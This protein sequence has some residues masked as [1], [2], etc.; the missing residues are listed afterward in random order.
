MFISR[1]MLISA[2]LEGASS[3]LYSALFINWNIFIEIKLHQN[4]VV[5]CQSA[6]FL[7]FSTLL[8]FIETKMPCYL[9]FKG[10]NFSETRHVNLMLFT[11]ICYYLV[12]TYVKCRVSECCNI[13]PTGKWSFLY[14]HSWCLNTIHFRIRIKMS[15][16]ALSGLS[17]GNP[18]F[19]H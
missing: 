4:K 16:W 7:N 1:A 12:S 3:M 13:G 18:I 10:Y 5:S 11:A 14:L 17:E 8:C 15:F 19:Q 2:G 9:S 6:D